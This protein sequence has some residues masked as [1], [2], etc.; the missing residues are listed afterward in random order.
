VSPVPAYLVAGAGG[1]LGHA[2]RRAIAA[3]GE[4]CVAPAEAAFDITDAAAVHRAVGAFAVAYGTDG[5][6]LNAAAY[7]DVEAAEAHAETAFRVN[8][9]GPR[10]LAAAALD[11]GIG[12][13]HVSTDFVFDGAKGAPYTE[14]DEPHPLSVYGASKLAG[15]RA[16][17]AANPG[18]LVVR[19]AWTFGEDGA[20]F[21]AKILAVAAQRGEVRVVTD[22]IGSPTYTGDLAPAILRLL[23][24]GAAGLFH[25]T[26][27]G[28]C[29]R[30]ELAEETLR[31]SGSDARLVPV[32]SDEFPAIA[33]RPR[34]CVLDCGRAAALGV[35]LPEWRDG[36]RRY[37]ARAPRT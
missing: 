32:T 37:L 27:A 22:E 5:V 11:T 19:T 25:L 6:L 17:A 10:L 28:S 21:P 23:D 35:V 12:F 26:G 29:T 9:T 34:A 20:T 16:V 24:A 36:L 31:L 14:A 8:E 4:T 1:M 15:E 3:R 18:A 7:T 30:F 2:L 13:V 33:E